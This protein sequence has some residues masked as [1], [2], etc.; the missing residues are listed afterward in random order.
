MSRAAFAITVP[1]LIATILALL[2]G[3]LIG[4]SFQ[5]EGCRFAR[6]GDAVWSAT[7]DLLLA[8]AV[9][10]GLLALLIALFVKV[11]MQRFQTLGIASGFARWIVIF[12]AAAFGSATIM[13]VIN[14]GLCSRS[15]PLAMTA[16]VFGGLAGLSALAAAASAI[17]AFVQGLSAGP[18]KP[19]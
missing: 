16:T 3:Y 14:Q 1:L 2:G 4:L 10:G 17:M 13:L 9:F 8:Q 18:D 6:T 7:A 5:G 15:G 12:A 19:A 11:L